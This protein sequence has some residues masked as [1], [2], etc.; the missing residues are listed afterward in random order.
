MAPVLRFSRIVL[1]LV[2]FLA[3]ATSGTAW[4]QPSDADRAAAREMGENAV[5]AYKA[6]EFGKAYDL[7]KRAHEIV[8]LT[9]TGLYMARCLVELGRFV[10]ASER[11]VEVTRMTLGD[12]ALDIH[13]EAKV[14][15]QKERDALLPRI[16][17]LTIVLGENAGPDT[18]VTLDG[19]AVPP[20][21]L[22]VP[23]P[24]DPGDHVV[25]V[26]RGEASREEALT[27]AE[28]ESR[29]VT[30]DLDATSTDPQPPPPPDPTTPAT[31]DGSLLYTLGWVGVGVGGAGLVVGAITG[32]LA[33]DKRSSLETAC[34]E[35][36]QCAPPL[37]GDVDTYQTLRIVSGVGFIAGGLIAATGIV[38][39]IV[40]PSTP[41]EPA[42]QLRMTPTGIAFT[43][44]F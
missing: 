43:G 30:L 22:G 41:A 20:A 31:D 15:A 27:L 13:Q 33:L 12:D 19:V 16:P 29:T 17:K 24:V 9:T 7:F 37:H 36:K 39:L 4:A 18:A 42:A 44:T 34:G 14:T 8:G 28:G 1:L 35:T 2:A 3:F 10:E 40:A 21:L 11:Y 32:A 38:L 23:R 26:Q 6:G 5:A 25:A